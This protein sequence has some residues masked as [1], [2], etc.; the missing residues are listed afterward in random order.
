MTGDFKV[1]ADDEDIFAF[2]TKN[3]DL[4][5]LQALK[6]NGTV[7]FKLT[8]ELQREL[9]RELRYTLD[10]NTLS[11]IDGLTITLNMAQKDRKS[12]SAELVLGTSEKDSYF[13]IKAEGKYS[14]GSRV[15]I[16][17]DAVD[18]ME[19]DDD[20][21]LEY[22]KAIDLSTVVRNLKKAKV[23]KE[24]VDAISEFNGEA[25]A[26]IIESYTNPYGSSRYNNR[27]D[28]YDWWN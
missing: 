3:L 4:E 27:A 19:L 2:S 15:S 28:N 25:L 8:E 16:P 20:E 7:S 10:K 23:E 26:N 9:R 14:S 24:Y 18:V 17:K 22:V 21:A 12:G 13:K 6:A 11:L 5:G 1:F